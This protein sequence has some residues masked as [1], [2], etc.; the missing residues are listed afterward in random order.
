MELSAL[1]GILT[2]LHELTEYQ[3]PVSDTLVQTMRLVGTSGGPCTQLLDLLERL[4]SKVEARTRRKL[5]LWP[6]R[7][8]EVQE[9][10]AAI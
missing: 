7:R 10:L 8:D 1:R 3:N 2:S 4:H 9:I 5:M 6:S